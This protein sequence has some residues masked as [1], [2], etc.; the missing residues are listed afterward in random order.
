MPILDSG[1]ASNDLRS[2]CTRVARVRLGSYSLQLPRNRVLRV[3]TGVVLLVGGTLSFLPILGIW[4]LPLGLAVLANDSPRIRRFHRKTSV[5][6]VGWWKGR[7]R[8]LE[9]G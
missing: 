7:V 6:L 1:S 3:G 8:K 9:A 4:M 5:A 2:W